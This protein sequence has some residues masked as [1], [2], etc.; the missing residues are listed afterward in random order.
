MCCRIADPLLLLLLFLL[1]LQMALHS[2]SYTWSARWCAA[3]ADR[4]LVE[5]HK[6]D[7]TDG[8]GA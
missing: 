3:R 2:C 4:L 6:A 7:L 8:V 1:L 5:Q